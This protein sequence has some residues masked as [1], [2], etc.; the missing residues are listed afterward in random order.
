[1]Q[2]IVIIETEGFAA[3]RAGVYKV[4]SAELNVIASQVPLRWV[5]DP[6]YAAYQG[7]YYYGLI[8]AAD[9]AGSPQEYVI[10][11]F[12]FPDGYP[13]YPTNGPSAQEDT[14]ND[15]IDDNPLPDV[16]T[17]PDTVLSNDNWTVPTVSTNALPGMA[18]VVEMLRQVRDM[19]SASG[20]GV[21]SQVDASGKAIE[22]RIVAGAER[23][24]GSVEAAATGIQAD[25]R[26]GFGGVVDA[27]NNSGAAVS[28]RLDRL[29]GQ[30]GSG[31]EFDAV[32]TNGLPD[33]GTNFSYDAAGSVTGAVGDVYGITNSTLVTWIKGKVV[34]QGPVIGDC[35]AVDWSIDTVLPG[36]RPV[37]IPIMVR[38]S[39]FPAFSMIRA[40]QLWLLRLWGLY[41]T[42]LLVRWM[43]S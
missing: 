32:V 35:T 39:D 38:F 2:W 34:V 25:L 14:F 15:W 33:G 18:E 27:V 40:L 4:S 42:C 36:N 9:A 16:P 29:S 3:D 37:R 6:A 11:T 7:G 26:T 43:I 5:P 23:V 17:V 1:L 13:D 24:S 10:P 41:V 8:D 22:G 20:R 21:Q 19:V 30:V 31:G 12:T 28:E